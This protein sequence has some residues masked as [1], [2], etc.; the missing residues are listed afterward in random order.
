MSDTPATERPVIED[1]SQNLPP[2][3]ASEGLTVGRSD[4]QQRVVVPAEVVDAML[5]EQSLGGSGEQAVAD[6][7]ARLQP[8]LPEGAVASQST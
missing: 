8:A 5:D 2:E 6:N 1:D 7:Q 3:V 4:G